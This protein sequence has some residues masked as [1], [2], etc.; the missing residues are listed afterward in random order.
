[1]FIDGQEKGRLVACRRW[2][3]GGKYG[4]TVGAAKKGIEGSAR[5]RLGWSGRGEGG[6]FSD[7]VGFL[8]R[9]RRG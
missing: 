4:I 7:S 3:R 1:M 5:I 8:V 9:A 2:G 6:W